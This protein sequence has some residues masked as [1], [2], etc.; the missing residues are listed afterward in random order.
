MD[1]PGGAK[2]LRQPKLGGW[3]R[4]FLSRYDQTP[5]YYLTINMPKPVILIGTGRF[6]NRNND[7]LVRLVPWQTGVLSFHYK[8]WDGKVPD[9]GELDKRVRTLEKVKK[10]LLKSGLI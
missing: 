9:P 2:D 5:A 7:E 6:L 1:E 3:G 10:H 4:V 8:N